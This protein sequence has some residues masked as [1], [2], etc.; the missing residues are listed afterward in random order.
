MSDIP[1]LLLAAGAS[2]RMRGRDKLMEEVDG[3]PLVAR[4]ARMARAATDGAVLV[5]LPPQPHPRHGA[6][7]GLDIVPVEVPEAAEGMGSSIRTGIGAL[8]EGARAVMVLLADLPDLRAADLR[9]VLQAVKDR[10]DMQVWRGA[11]EDG[12]AGHPIVFAAALFPDLAALAGDEGG[13]SVV[14]A[15]GD[16]MCL[17]PLPGQ[18][19]LADLDTPEAWAAWRAARGK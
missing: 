12:R 2:N 18:Q 5:T 13:R 6:L 14:A 9:T 7:K 10:P 16:R 3:Q 4:M 15:A 8:P 19:A 17:V 11:T 1:I